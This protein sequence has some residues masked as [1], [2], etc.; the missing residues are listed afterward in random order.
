M[1]DEVKGVLRGMFIYS[2]KYLHYKRVKFYCKF[3]YQETRKKKK[4]LTKCKANRG[5]NII[6]ILEIN[7]IEI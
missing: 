7:N 3:L 2:T 5:K 6:K 4:K 1:W